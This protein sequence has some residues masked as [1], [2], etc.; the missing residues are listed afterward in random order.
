[1]ADI[2]N[3]LDTAQEDL[4]TTKRQ[5][6]ASK[7][8]RI[9]GG[10]LQEEVATVRTSYDALLKETQSLRAD[11]KNLRKDH[12]SLMEENQSLRSSTRTMMKEV[13]DLRHELEAAHQEGDIA[14]E[15]IDQLQN[16]IQL[17]E[18]AL[19]SQK[20]E[21]DSLVRHNDRYFSDNKALRHEQSER[22]RRIHDLDDEN[23]RLREE[24]EFLKQQLDHCRPVGNDLELSGRVDETEEN[25]T[26]AFLIPDITVQTN[27]ANETGQSE[28]RNGRTG[29][30][31]QGLDFTED[32][33]VDDVSQQV[34]EPKINKKM[35]AV[36]QNAQKVAF[37]LPERENTAGSKTQQANKGSKRRSGA[38]RST[39]GGVTDTFD[40]FDDDFSGRVSLDNTQNH[41]V[42][43]DIPVKSKKEAAPVQPSKPKP[44]A[45]TQ[46]ETTEQLHRR[47]TSMPTSRSQ[48]NMT[49]EFT[50]ASQNA[51]ATATTAKGTCPALSP[52]ARRV[53]DGLCVHDCRNCSVCA[54]VTSHR[55]ALSAL[56]LISGKK[57]ITVPVPTPISQQQAAADLQDTRDNDVTLR[58][59]QPPS[60]ALHFVIKVTEDEIAHLKM[61]VHTLNDR[62]GLCD[63]SKDRRKRHALERERDALQRE[64]SAKND[65]HY[66][67]HDV[68]EQFR[69]EAVGEE[70]LEVTVW[71]ATGVSIGDVTAEQLL[72]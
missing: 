72:A 28:V 1:M 45:P 67:L 16:E 9:N 21:H 54:R 6:E 39:R 57:R 8:A 71:E 59:S 23:T 56:E 51:T 35:R 26:S 37:S 5:L 17:L 7:N 60:H 33:R 64:L 66:A 32:S 10:D 15:D 12:D 49:T 2:V 20:A 41:S 25:M 22:E 50:N 44:A 19:A 62:V 30:K 68:L 18:D 43:F 69:D 11:N 52:D 31:S 13:D 27:D 55:G 3:K 24:I 34:T 47:R 4:R 63:G 70:E 48:Q 14:K 58:P 53:L 29:G 42:T 40:R 61:K 38:S 46:R 65:V 36:A